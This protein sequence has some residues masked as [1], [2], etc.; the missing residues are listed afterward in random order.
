V[1]FSKAGE[2]INLGFLS[3]SICGG[4]DAD[5]ASLRAFVLKFH[6]ATDLGKKSVILPQ[7]Y[8]QTRLEASTPLS[9]QDGPARHRLTSEP[10]HAQPLGIGITTI[11]GTAYTFFMCHNSSLI[12]PN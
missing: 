8:I 1:K 3:G 5:K 2:K 4:D 7:A 12:I 6:N 9:H 10:F 11:S